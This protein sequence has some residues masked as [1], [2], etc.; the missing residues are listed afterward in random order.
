MK[1][2]IIFSEKKQKKKKKK[3]KKKEKKEN[4]LK[5]PSAENFFNQ[6]AKLIKLINDFV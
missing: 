6:H 5:M 4:Y 1:C 3:K 2:Q